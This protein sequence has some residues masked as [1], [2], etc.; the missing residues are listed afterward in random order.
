MR[1]VIDT[2]V[3]VSAFI[4][5]QSAAGRELEQARGGRLIPLYS[6]AML[7]EVLNVF[8]RPRM[9]RRYHISA[10]DIAALFALLQAVGEPVIVQIQVQDCRDLKDN[11]FLEAALAGRAEWIISGDDDL[12]ALHPWRGI[13][14]VSPAQAVARLED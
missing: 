3:L 10:D 7:D 13:E 14:I 2:N 8:S 9:Q 5:R 6:A 11:K 4:K 1:A 12:H